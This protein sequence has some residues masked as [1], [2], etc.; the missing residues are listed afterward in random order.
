MDKKKTE[1]L[2]NVFASVFTDNLSSH[3][4][5]VDGPKDGTWRIKVPPTVRADEA[6]EHLRNLNIQKSIGPDEMHPRILMELADVVAK[7]PSVISEKSRQS[8]KDPGDWRKENIVSI[9]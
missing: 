7:P 5:R 8:G 9:F 2:N 4:S 3:T 1:V 6:W